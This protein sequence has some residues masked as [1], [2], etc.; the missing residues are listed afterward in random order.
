M[1][2]L[3]VVP[4]VKVTGVGYAG[5][6]GPSRRT[7]RPLRL[8]YPPMPGLQLPPGGAIRTRC[9]GDGFPVLTG[10]GA[11]VVEAMG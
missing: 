5:R 8:T 6:V 4:L 2:D 10:C 11:F 3:R 7:T 9:D 1:G